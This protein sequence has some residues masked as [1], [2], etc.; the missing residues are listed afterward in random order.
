MALAKMTM[1]SNIRVLRFCLCN[2]L[3]LRST[4]V[5]AALHC[6]AP[7]FDV[8]GRLRYLKVFLPTPY[9]LLHSIY[10]LRQLRGEQSAR[11][12]R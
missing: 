6:I 8:H 1:G 12:I 11:L 4:D 10:T 2:D 3:P 9:K 7:Q 5:L